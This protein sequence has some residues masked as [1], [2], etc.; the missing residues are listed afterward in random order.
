M[1]GAGTRAGAGGG[2][3]A[4]D[5]ACAGAGQCA[6]GTVGC[7]GA[8]GTR[9][10]GGLPGATGGASAAGRTGDADE[11]RR[12][13][14]TGAVEVAAVNDGDVDGGGEGA[15]DVRPA[16]CTEDAIE[17]TTVDVFVP[18]E[19]QAAPAPAENPTKASPPRVMS[20]NDRANGRRVT[21]M[22]PPLVRVRTTA[23]PALASF[24]SSCRV[25]AKGA[26]MAFQCFAH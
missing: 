12:V 8:T 19:S 16:C 23:A 17:S 4:G 14:L 5:G 26:S 11:G 7:A 6:A 2:T 21:V 20:G 24:F 1:P 13:V 10:A 18:S 15:G 25:N 22:E 3:G 9:T